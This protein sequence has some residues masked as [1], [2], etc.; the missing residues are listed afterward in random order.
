MM[1]LPAGVELGD[2]ASVLAP[3]AVVT[4][5]LRA[6]PFSFVHRLAGSEFLRRLSV[7]MP[8]GVM[9]VLVVYTIVGY[10]PFG[11]GTGD[12]SAGSGSFSWSATWSALW[13]AL[14]ASAATAAVH[15]WRRSVGL[16]I[17][18]GTAL[19]MVLVNLL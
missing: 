1:G 18:V 7:T 10:L 8:I 17:L 19:Y 4:V 2:V 5:A 16:S 15:L 14:A 9:V 6:L 12:S 13:P 11:G 3:V